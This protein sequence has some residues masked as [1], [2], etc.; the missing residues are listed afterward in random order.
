MKNYK[1]KSV[2]KKIRIDISSIEDLV[3]ALN[4]DGYNVMILTKMISKRKSL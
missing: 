4:N 3:K 1:N 2:E